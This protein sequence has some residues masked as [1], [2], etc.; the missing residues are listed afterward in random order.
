MKK[1]P[2]AL[3]F[4]MLFVT[5]SFAQNE[6]DALRYSQVFPGGTARFA[7]MGG[8]FGALG[9]DFSSLS[10]NPAGIG[11][12]RKSEITITPA[13][14]YSLVQTSYFNTAEEE[15]KYNFNL[16]N[17]G[18]VFTFPTAKPGVDRGWQFVNIGLGI[19]RHNGFNDRW[20]ARGFNS[21]NSFMTSILEEA[22]AQGSVD[23]LNDFSS[24][25][26][27]DTYLLGW[28]NDLQ[29][30][31]VDMPNGQVMQRIEHNT[32]GSIREFLIS[33]GANY[34][35]RLYLGATIGF[36]S[37][38]FKEDIVYSEKDI[39]GLSEYFNALTYTNSLETSGS[40]YNFKMGAI[41]RLTDYLRI[42]GAFHTPTFYE[43]EDKYKA[44]MRSDM[45]LP[46]YNDFARSP[47]G[48][49]KY[50]INTP[51]KAI[52][53]LGLV[54]GNMGMINIDYEYI[55]YTTARL[56]TSDIRFTE[57]ISQANDLVRDA[58]SE[59]HN[60]RIGGELRLNFI[61]L[62]AGY[63]YYSS[64]YRSGINDDQRTIISAGFGI[65]ESNYSLD[66]AY[67]HTFFS[68]DYSMYQ[69]E[70][71]NPLVHRDFSASTFRATLAWRF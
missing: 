5:A 17:I 25:L 42:G 59:Q 4:A 50:E 56:R 58:F 71:L 40:G 47:E 26:A 48:R 21:D 30:F 8:S 24:G 66:F 41:F 62:R 70:G 68:D 7:A 29:S 32:T 23:R 28:N 43:L 45:N 1:Y 54:F 34:N 51:L 27:W 57:E 38:N 33:M 14:N 67:S 36:P 18:A 49:F 2:V 61:A 55:D 3:L 20:L 15:M 13:L 22:Q 9:G 31:F 10:V 12:Y 46:D 63:A 65:R 37:V 16:N 60:I 19:N 69:L 6:T 39:E 35:D 52:G 11:I 53:S 44:T 64:P